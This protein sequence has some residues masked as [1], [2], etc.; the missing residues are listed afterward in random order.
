MPRLRIVNKGRGVISLKA[1]DKFPYKQQNMF[2]SEFKVNGSEERKFVVSI[3]LDGEGSESG[4]V[5]LSQMNFNENELLELRNNIDELL[6]I[7]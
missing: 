6:K 1:S 4:R 7:Q 2:I 5:K 3:R